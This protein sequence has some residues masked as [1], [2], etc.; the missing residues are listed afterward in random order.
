MRPVRRIQGETLSFTRRLSVPT[1]AMALGPRGVASRQRMVS[2]A[3]WG[4]VPESSMAV[5]LAAAG[6][7]ASQIMQN[8]R[9]V[10]GRV[11]VPD[12]TALRRRQR[13]EHA[14]GVGACRGSN[15]VL[16]GKGPAAL[17]P[18]VLRDRADGLHRTAGE[19]AGRKGLPARVAI[20]GAGPAYLGEGDGVAGGVGVFFWHC[21]GHRDRAGTPARG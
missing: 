15:R 7:A 8:D 17:G 18:L 12:A 5:V 19:G 9:T 4:S 6:S 10:S 3:S 11:A 16:V 1:I 13:V 14:S 2:A 21:R 20:A